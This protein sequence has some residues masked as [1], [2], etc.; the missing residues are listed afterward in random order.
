MVTLRLVRKWNWAWMRPTKWSETNLESTRQL[1]IIWRHMTL[2]DS[3]DYVTGERRLCTPTKPEI[4]TVQW[5]SFFLRKTLNSRLWKTH[6]KKGMEKYEKSCDDLPSS[7]KSKRGGQAF[8]ILAISTTPIFWGLWGAFHV[9]CAQLRPVGT[10]TSLGS[11][12]RLPTWSAAPVSLDRPPLS[13]RLSARWTQCSA[14]PR[15]REVRSRRA[16]TA[17]APHTFWPCSGVASLVKMV[18]ERH[19]QFFWPFLFD[20][21]LKRKVS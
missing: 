18:K 4:N 20:F 8:G 21:F 1:K 2:C 19:L 12:R 14:R 17:D 15:V 10:T 6:G 9:M 7:P 11:V 13:P 5:I 16:T 3:Q